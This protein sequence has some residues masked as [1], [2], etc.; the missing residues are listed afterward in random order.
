MPAPRRG[1]TQLALL[2]PLPPTRPRP[3]RR[4]QSEGSMTFGGVQFFENTLPLTPPQS[5]HPLRRRCF[6]RGWGPVSKSVLESVE[7]Y[8]EGRDLEGDQ[9]V[10]AA[11]AKALASQLDTAV[12]AGTARGVSACPRLARRLVEGMDVFS[13]R[14]AA[15]AE[16]E[17]LEAAC[18]QARAAPP[19]GAL[20]GCGERRMRSQGPGRRDC[21]YSSQRSTR[22]VAALA[23]ADTRKRQRVGATLVGAVAFRFSRRPCHRRAVVRLRISWNRGRPL[24][25]APA[26]ST[27]RDRRSSLRA[28]HLAARVLD[29]RARQRTGG[30]EGGDPP[31]GPP[32]D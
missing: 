5:D 1:A 31:R 30:G 27:S 7:R 20:G 21:C 17:R 28:G 29:R 16:R 9:V 18:S 8:L 19:R 26:V 22:V 4:A 2:P 15:E 25:R 14:D 13:G 3:R 12:A 6:A 32:R 11:V 23:T 10:L 24:A